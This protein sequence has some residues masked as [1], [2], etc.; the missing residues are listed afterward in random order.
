MVCFVA[1]FSSLDI[2][3]AITQSDTWPVKIFPT[4]CRLHLYYNVGILCCLEDFS[5]SLDIMCQLL[6]SV[7]LLLQACSVNSFLYL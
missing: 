7:P 2:L 3:D 4:F 6:V 1:V 5:V